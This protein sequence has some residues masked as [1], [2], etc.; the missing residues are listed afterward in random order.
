[1]RVRG[2]GRG[3]VGERRKRRG[4]REGKRKEARKRNT[5]AGVNREGFMD[6]KEEWVRGEEEEK[7]KRKRRRKKISEGEREERRIPA[8][9]VCG[10]MEGKTVRRRRK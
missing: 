7:W 9:T 3:K 2:G 5:S 8:K 10:E 6:R 4:E 1:M